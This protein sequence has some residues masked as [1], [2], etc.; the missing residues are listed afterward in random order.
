MASEIKK[1]RLIVCAHAVYPDT[2]SSEGIV[3]KNW[4]A[5]LQDHELNC[6]LISA[7]TTIAVVKD[8][9]PKTYQS[10]YLAFLWQLFLAPKTSVHGLL[11][12]VMNKI[13]IKLGWL[14][15]RVSLYFYL[16]SKANKKRLLLALMHRTDLVVWARVISTFSLLPVLAAWKKKPFPL[17]INVNDPIEN[18]FHEVLSLEEKL[19]LKT[20]NKA[21][22]WTFPSKDLAIE[23]AKKFDLDT[24]RC[25][26][27]PH[28][29]RKQEQLY[30]GPKDKDKKL[31]FIYT[32]TFYKT[33]FSDAF[34]KDLKKFSKSAL[35][36]QVTF[37]FI[38]SQFD[39]YALQWIKNT[40]PS[41]S[42]KTK[43]AREAVLQITAK[44]DCMI[45]TDA[46]HHKALLK[47]KLIEAIAQGTP[48]FA[49]TYQNSVMDRVVTEYGCTPAYQDINH[50]VYEK[51]V[52]L[53]QNL[54]KQEWCDSFFEKRKNIMQKISEENIAKT[55]LTIMEYA[56]NRF[57]WQQG[58]TNSEPI[59]PSDYNWP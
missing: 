9:M 3:N 44:A 43:L 6:T 57:S 58:Q 20:R 2:P 52:A 55:S 1:S 50:D 37:T 29:M 41:A 33:A 17:I 12:K 25:F 54:K 32:G 23:V 46:Q 22:C 47:G 19:F 45:V 8:S 30:L 28:A 42:I 18:Y 38:L 48:I 36:E 15:K 31:N 7:A 13:A 39:D 59:P 53:T 35:S 10:R 51:L 24:N 16:W 56:Q 21:Q 4:L 34:K 11:Y 40:L 27:I 5:I 26:V 49:V 14:P